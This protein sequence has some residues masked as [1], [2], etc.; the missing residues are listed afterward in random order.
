MELYIVKVSFT[1]KKKAVHIWHLLDFDTVIPHMTLPLPYVFTTTSFFS[2][3]HVA[4]V[5]VK[6]G[7]EF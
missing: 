3:Q 1:C 4:V 2:Q 5:G 7:I 6:H